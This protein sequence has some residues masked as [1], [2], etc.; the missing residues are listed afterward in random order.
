MVA[1]EEYDYCLLQGKCLLR[2]CNKDSNCC[3]KMS[4]L[5]RSVASDLYVPQQILFSAS[6]KIHAKAIEQQQELYIVFVD[7][8][9]AF[10]TVDRDLLW[11]VCR[12]FGCLEW[13]VEMIRLFHDGMKATLCVGDEQSNSFHI[14]HGTKQGCVMRLKLQRA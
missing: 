1:T 7:F 3:L 8:S 5:S 11:K 12:L 2:Y 10:Y 14:N 9:K 4:C 13:L 6:V